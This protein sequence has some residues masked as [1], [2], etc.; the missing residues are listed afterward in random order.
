[1]SAATK[2][3]EWVERLRAVM[4][5]GSSTCSKAARYMPDEPGVIVRG[6]GC[7]VWDAD[8]R[9]FIDFRNALGPVTLGYAFG[10]VDE[11]VRRQLGSGIVYGQPHTLECEVAEMLCEVVP[12]AEQARFLKTGGEAIAACMRLA[13]FHTGRDHI[14]QIGYNGWLNS[15]AAGGR[16]LPGQVSSAA[17]PGVPEALSKLHHAAAW[18]DIASVE[19]AFD[20]AKGE[21][22]AVVVAASYPDM[23]A[24]AG[25][26]PALRKLTRE[27]GALLV[28]DEIVTGFRVA[29]A[30][31]QEYFGVEPDLAV[32]AKGM[33]NGLPISVYLGRREIMGGLEK[34]IVSSTYG[35]E[36]LSLAA[37][38]A[39][40]TVYR[41]EGVIDHI[42][43]Q[44]EA[45]WG[46]LNRIF[47]EKSLPVRM[48]GLWPCPAVK[49]LPEAPGDLLEK[50][51]RAAYR[52]GVSLYGVSYVNFSHK[53]D[54]IAEAL[55]RMGTACGEI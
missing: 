23:A 15:L 12:S 25:F 3:A 7:R 39:A 5:W 31:V 9:E 27:R 26:Y 13:R 2:S 24:G 34:V 11:A 36:T 37:A 55:E 43:R 8:G 18:N 16:T 33:A 29:L 50:L 20:D 22:A 45:M 6:R 48:T 10:P 47:E 32:F 14:V 19:Q 54:D 30:G 51:F 17:P 28:F 35:G 44:G 42:W 49:P 1:M 46:G 41:N 40:I 52:N 38:K 4:P 21:V 53:D